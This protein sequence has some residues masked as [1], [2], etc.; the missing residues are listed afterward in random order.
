MM[1]IEERLEEIAAEIGAPPRPRQHPVESWIKDVED[2]CATR[3]WSAHQIQL[4][5]EFR[6][7]SR[8]YEKG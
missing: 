3:T 7:L 4:I 2:F 6:R 8:E 5:D 1:R